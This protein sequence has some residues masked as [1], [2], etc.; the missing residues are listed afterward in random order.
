MS[1]P[2]SEPPAYTGGVT[3][4]GLE[5]L[6]VDQVGTDV[7]EPES[8]AGSSALLILA[9][10]V[11]MGLVFGFAFAIWLVVGNAWFGSSVPVLFEWF[12][13]LAVGR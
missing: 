2:Y 1:S 9:V 6:D 8:R 5:V 13:V 4:T 12:G 7:E 11:G 3:D 10:C